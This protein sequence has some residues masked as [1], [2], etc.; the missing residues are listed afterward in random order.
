LS[1]SR[2]DPGP[3]QFY[4]TFVTLPRV[5][6]LAHDASTFRHIGY[7]K[8]GKV[9]I[10]RKT[11]IGAG[12]I[13]LPGVTIGD[14]VIIGAGSVVSKNIP[15]N[16]VAAGNPAVVIGSTSDY[17]ERHRNNMEHSPVFN[18]GW[19][20]GSGITEQNKQIMREKLQDGIGYNL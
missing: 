2:L 1:K 16:S 6:I 19:T 18:E 3:I 13:I 17:I 5:T 11:F 12:S 8:V 14:N 4:R 7:T 9:T 20:L 15:D 10:G